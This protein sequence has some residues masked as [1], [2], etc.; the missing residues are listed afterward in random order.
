[1]PWNFRKVLRFGPFRI[2]VGKRGIT[3]IGAGPVT[4][5]RR[6][7]ARTTIR[8]GIPGLSFSFGG[9]AKRKRH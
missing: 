9:K 6:K 1:M 8:T 4:K 2:G 7:T 5:S 3:S